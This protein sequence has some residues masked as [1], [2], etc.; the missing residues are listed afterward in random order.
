M[1]SSL[2][3]DLMVEGKQ[4]VTDDSAS[5][6]SSNNDISDTEMK[7][8]KWSSTIAGRRKLT[9]TLLRQGNP[10]LTRFI[11]KKGTP[12]RIVR[13]RMPRT[14]RDEDTNRVRFKCY[15]M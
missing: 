3:H 7:E 11:K 9:R 14:H 4:D 10:K 5:I 12:Y 2:Q 13:R 15:Q 1:D 8:R 6:Q